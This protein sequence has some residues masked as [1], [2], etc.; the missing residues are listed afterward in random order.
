MTDPVDDPRGLRQAMVDRLAASGAL[1][2]SWRAAFLAV[3]RHWFIP[4]LVWREEE[5][6]P[7][8]LL[9]QR[10]ADDP[11]GWL[12]RAYADVSVVTQVDDGN[13]VGPG[14]AGRL[15]TS[16]ASMPTRNSCPVW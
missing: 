4:D 8:Y 6:G 9:P 2:S 10:R 5:E 16:S 7:Q 11:D 1:A 14:L 13:P 15:I 3:P 12:A